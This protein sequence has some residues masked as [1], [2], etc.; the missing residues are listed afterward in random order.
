MN[1][2]SLQTVAHEPPCRTARPFRDLEDDGERISSDIIPECPVL[3]PITM[4]RR[5][6][7]DGKTLQSKSVMTL[8]L[9]FE[10]GMLIQEDGNI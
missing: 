7:K 1:I 6:A 10:F 3:E 5:A 2:P 4:G 8:D 9:T